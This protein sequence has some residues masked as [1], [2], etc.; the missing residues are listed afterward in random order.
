MV[1][2]DLTDEELY[3]LHKGIEE[4]VSWLGAVVLAGSGANRE[5][6]AI[7]LAIAEHAA[8]KVRSALRDVQV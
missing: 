3:E 1:I 5:A 4:R 2:A 7:S 8:Y 6:A